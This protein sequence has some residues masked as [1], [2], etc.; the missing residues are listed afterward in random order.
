MLRSALSEYCWHTRIWREWH[1][2]AATSTRAFLA[3]NMTL[4]LAT[5]ATKATAN[6]IVAARRP[7]IVNMLRISR[8]LCITYDGKVL[9]VPSI[10]LIY[11]IWMSLEIF[12]ALCKGKKSNHMQYERHCSR[13]RFQP[14]KRMCSRVQDPTFK[15]FFWGQS[16]NFSLLRHYPTGLPIASSL[17]PNLSCFLLFPFLCPF[18]IGSVY[19]MI[20]FYS[21]VDVIWRWWVLKRREKK[22]GRNSDS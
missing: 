18:L 4:E 15:R 3:W 5:S 16:H 22:K 13:G 14:L 20:G 7:E 11:G 6:V 10:T 8:T 2:G 19:T 12:K 1:T 17:P 9:E 21:A